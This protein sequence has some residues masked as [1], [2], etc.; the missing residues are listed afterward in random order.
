VAAEDTTS[1]G[2]EVGWWIFKATAGAAAKDAFTHKVKLTLN[3]GDIE[4]AAP[5]R[6][7]PVQQ[8]GKTR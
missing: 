6:T 1:V 2:G 4:V 8:Q 3:V 5:R 7:G